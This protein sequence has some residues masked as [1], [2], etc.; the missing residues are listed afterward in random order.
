M[1][2]RVFACSGIFHLHTGGSRT[3][4][5]WTLRKIPIRLWG[6]PVQPVL[7]TEDGSCLGP[8]SQPENPFFVL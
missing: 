4:L 3:W 7:G 6:F 1:S 5:L 8:G 2:L